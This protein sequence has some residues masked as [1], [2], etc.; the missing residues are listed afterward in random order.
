MAQ[1]ERYPLHRVVQL[2]ILTFTWKVRR[3]A[4]TVAWISW[5]R[6]LSCSRLRVVTGF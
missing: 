4:T 1:Q 6:W 2:R 3:T 5:R